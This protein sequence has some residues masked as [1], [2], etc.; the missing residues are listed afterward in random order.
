MDLADGAVL[1]VFLLAALL[2][3][4]SSLVSRKRLIEEW[5]PKNH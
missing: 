2:V 5:T 3:V 4:S 1:A